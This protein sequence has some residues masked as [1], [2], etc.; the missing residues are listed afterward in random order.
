MDADRHWNRI[1]TPNAPNV[2]LS[3]KWVPIKSHPKPFP[4]WPFSSECFFF[5][6]GGSPLVLL[7]LQI[8][9]AEN[10]ISAMVAWR[11]QHI[12]KKIHFDSQITENIPAM[13]AHLSFSLYTRPLH[14][15]LLFW[16]WLP[17]PWAIRLH[18]RW[19][20]W[21]KPPVLQILQSKPKSTAS[22]PK[23]F[24]KWSTIAMYFVFSDLQEQFPA[25]HQAWAHRSK[26]NPA[27]QYYEKVNSTGAVN[28][29]ERL[30]PSS[31]C[32]QVRFRARRW[33]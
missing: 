30:T 25:P 29:L 2:R 4:S 27:W 9:T 32:I 18:T 15:V 23:G 3:P 20:E 1:F 21:V 31:V 7:K 17:E 13:P 16:K 11:L 8:K 12:L 14:T 6:C 28:I 22:I 24:R 33:L 5:F 10:N 26:Q 19:S